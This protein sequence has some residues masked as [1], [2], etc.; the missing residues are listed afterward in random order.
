MK[1]AI[2]PNGSFARNP[3]RELDEDQ[4]EPVARLDRAAALGAGTPLGR[5]QAGTHTSAWRP[6]TLLSGHTAR[7]LRAGDGLGPNPHACHAPRARARLSRQAT[8]GTLSDD[9]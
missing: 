5:G 1:T 3:V 6:M 7:L 4:G 9:R 8:E 2:E